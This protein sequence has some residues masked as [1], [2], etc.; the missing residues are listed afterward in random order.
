ML[1]GYEWEL[2]K[3][4]AGVT[5]WLAKDCAKSTIPDRTTVEEARR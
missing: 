2:V 1:F 3:S 4:P 5:A